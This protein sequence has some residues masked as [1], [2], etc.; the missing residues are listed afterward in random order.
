M[1]ISPQR[2][3]EIKG[4]NHELASPLSFLHDHSYC[5]KVGKAWRRQ[6]PAKVLGDWEDTATCLPLTPQHTVFRRKGFVTHPKKRAV[7]ETDLR[8][9]NTRVDWPYFHRRDR[10]AKY[11][12]RL[13]LKDSFQSNQSEETHIK[14]QKKKKIN[15]RASKPPVKKHI[16]NKHSLDGVRDPSLV[17]YSALMSS[18]LS[19]LLPEVSPALIAKAKSCTVGLTP[20]NICLPSPLPSSPTQSSSTHQDSSSRSSSTSPATHLVMKP[21]SISLQKIPLTKHITSPC[22]KSTILE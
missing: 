11:K 21:F 16:Q 2:P 7:I 12:A 17:S 9:D 22:F 5:V 13:K 10:N 8:V 3:P 15:S 19:K 1:L 4:P 18:A 6:V 20:T 14:P